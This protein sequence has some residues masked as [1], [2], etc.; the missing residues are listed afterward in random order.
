MDVTS[1]TI[2]REVIGRSRQLPVVVDF[3]AGCCAP[4]RVLGPAL[5]AEAAKPAGRLELVKVDVDA[6]PQLSIRDGIRTIPT[7]AV[8]RD[9]EPV[10]GFA[11]AQRAR[12]L[13]DCFDEQVLG[14]EVDQP[15]ADL[16]PAAETSRK[17]A[18]PTPARK[19]VI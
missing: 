4:C 18:V 11:G 17:T 5:E 10:T 8:F 1:E 14:E 2:R 6:E 13:G 12:M 9:G 15:R 3:W 7:V 19:D 16:R